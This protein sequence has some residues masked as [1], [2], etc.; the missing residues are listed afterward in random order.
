MG[1][2]VLDGGESLAN[3]LVK[4]SLIEASGSGER[5][6]PAA[7]DTDAGRLVKSPRVQGRNLAHDFVDTAAHVGKLDLQSRPM[8]VN[9]GDCA[10]T[11]KDVLMNAKKTVQRTRLALPSKARPSS[12]VS[13]S[14]PPCDRSLPSPVFSR[15]CSLSPTS[16]SSSCFSFADVGPRTPVS[17][18]K[19]E[20]HWSLAWNRARRLSIDARTPLKTCEQHASP[21]SKPVC[22][23]TPRAKHI[24]G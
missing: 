8:I 10:Q 23:Q 4:N 6:P 1:S 21:G 22:F 9:L 24:R 18:A 5:A 16:L 19:S 7:S 15:R 2:A 13:L 12:Q 17:A 20:Q 3:N 14:P 11:I